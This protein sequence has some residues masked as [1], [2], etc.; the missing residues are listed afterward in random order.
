MGG[1]VIAVNHIHWID[2]PAV[3]SLLP[4]RYRLC[5]F[6]KSEL[7]KN[8]LVARWLHA[9]HVLPV[10]RGKRDLAALDRAVEALQ[11]GAV[12]LIFP[13]GHRSATGQLQE[14]RSGAIRLA[15]RAGVP[16]VPVAIM[17]T[18]HGTQ[19]TLRSKPVVVRVGQ[20]YQVAMAADDKIPRELMANLTDDLMRRI[21]ALLPAEYHGVYRTA[22]D[23]AAAPTRSESGTTTTPTPPV[24]PVRS[25]AP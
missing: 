12:L 21:A 8:P 4:L 16:I 19:G 11:A 7:F 13:E 22:P 2:I 24:R 17:G 9:M 5:W 25:S 20:P 18:E 10:R 15:V 14:G 23:A 6:A 3:A 1:M